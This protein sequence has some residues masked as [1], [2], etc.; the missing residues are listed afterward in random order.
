MRQPRLLSAARI[1]ANLSGCLSG[2]GRIQR[3]IHDFTERYPFSVRRA[4]FAL[5]MVVKRT[6]KPLSILPAPAN[7][8]DAGG[9]PRG[10]GRRTSARPRFVER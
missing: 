5:A 2:K 3:F 8:V 9:S 1:A 10:C 4:R 6:L 7:A